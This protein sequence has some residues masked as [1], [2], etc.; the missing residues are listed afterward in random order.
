MYGETTAKTQFLSLDKPLV[1]RG[2]LDIVGITPKRKLKLGQGKLKRIYSSKKIFCPKSFQVVRGEDS[3]SD[4]EMDNESE[5]SKDSTTEPE[6][7]KEITEGEEKKTEKNLIE[8]NK[9]ISEIEEEKEESAFSIRDDK[10]SLDLEWLAIV[11]ATH[12][13]M[14]IGEKRCN[15]NQYIYPLQNKHNDLNIEKEKIFKEI[16]E[17]N[18]N[19]EVK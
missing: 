8:E 14:P 10:I 13:L 18:L 5:K 15:F 11:K 2:F 1:G 7:H 3:E 16:K 4:L 9:G 12:D 17:T 6:E 19:L